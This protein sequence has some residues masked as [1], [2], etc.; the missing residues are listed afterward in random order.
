MQKPSNSE[1]TFSCQYTLQISIKKFVVA[2]IKN[3]IMVQIQ[4][5][6]QLITM[7]LE[8]IVKPPFKVSLYSSWIKQYTGK[9]LKNRSLT[10]IWLTKDHWN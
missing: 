7:M 4:S 6:E 8:I 9:T 5:S 1:Q 10:L 2:Q 3:M